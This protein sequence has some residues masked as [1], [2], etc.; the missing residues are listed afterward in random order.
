M[1]TNSVSLYQI[2]ED[3]YFR[4]FKQFSSQRFFGNNQM[5]WKVISKEI[6]P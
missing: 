1:L 4:K 3:K 5:Q 2:G 6:E